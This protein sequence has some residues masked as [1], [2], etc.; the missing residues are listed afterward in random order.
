MDRKA[1]GEQNFRNMSCD[2]HVTY[3]LPKIYGARV[4]VIALE[5]SCAVQICSLFCVGLVDPY[6]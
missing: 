5:H 2:C 6:S 1:Q 4:E 3:A